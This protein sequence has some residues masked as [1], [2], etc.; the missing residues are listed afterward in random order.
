MTVSTRPRPGSPGWPHPPRNLAAANL[1]SSHYGDPARVLVAR[2]MNIRIVPADLVRRHGWGPESWRM[3]GTTS[4]TGHRGF[5]V[6]RSGRRAAGRRAAVQVSR[7]PGQSCVRNSSHPALAQRVFRAGRGGLAAIRRSAGRHRVPGPF[8]YDRRHCS[9]S[10][11]CVASH[12]RC[13]SDRPSARRLCIA[14]LFLAPDRGRWRRASMPGAARPRSSALC[15]IGRLRVRG[16]DL[17][18]P[19]R[20]RSA[21]GRVQTPAIPIIRRRDQPLLLALGQGSG[22]IRIHFAPQ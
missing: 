10:S 16:P 12:P 9:N 6:M 22:S 1:P 11:V 14:A 21:G 13:P 20:C 4:G 3:I 7:A 8:A 5:P 2:P 18:P 15:R 17:S 19:W